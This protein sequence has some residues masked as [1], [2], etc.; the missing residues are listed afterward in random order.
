MAWNADHTVLTFKLRNG[1]KFLNGDPIDA[2]AVKYTYDRVF[3][4]KGVTASLIAMAAVKDKNSITTQGDDTV[5]FTLSKANT[6]LLGN[7]AQFGNSILDPKVIKQHKTKAD[8]YAHDWLST[9]VGGTAQGPFQLDS[10]NSAHSGCSRPT[11]TTAGR[12]RR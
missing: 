9:N 8:P 5:K 11:R 3:D 12:S 2:K 6:L 4:Q 1:L 7:M 10:W